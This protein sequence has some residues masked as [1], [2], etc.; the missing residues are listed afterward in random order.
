LA[1]VAKSSGIRRTSIYIR[2]FEVSPD[3]AVILFTIAGA[4]PGR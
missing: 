2:R 3:A 1:E 4:L